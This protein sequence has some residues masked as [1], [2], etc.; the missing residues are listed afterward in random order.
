MSE[1]TNRAGV[2]FAKTARGHD[3]MAERRGG[4]S[5]RVRRVLILVDGKRSV[6][7][8]RELALADDLSH[9][10]GR[11]EEQGYI[12][13]VKVQDASGAGRPVTAPLPS[14]TAFR[15]LSDPP[16][17]AQI[18]MARN[19]MLNSLRTFC[20]QYAHVTLMATINAARSHEELRLLY[21]D[22]YRHIVDTRQGRR[23]AEDLR[24]QLLRVI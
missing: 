19:F 21:P 1:D 17:P 18:E 8:L 22:W 7:Q 16:D 11:L 9:T 20:G 3:E 5:P 12:E 14:I 4:L 15:A 13:P 10:L 2:V 23:R 6:A 24:E